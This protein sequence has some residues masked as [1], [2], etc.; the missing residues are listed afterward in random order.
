[1]QQALILIENRIHGSDGAAIGGI[2]QFEEGGL[3]VPLTKAVVEATWRAAQLI[4]S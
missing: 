1:M 2:L 3:R 4:E